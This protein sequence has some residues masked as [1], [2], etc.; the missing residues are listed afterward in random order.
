MMQDN[1]FGLEMMFEIEKPQL[2]PQ[3][4]YFKIIY[5]VGYLAISTK[6]N[7]IFIS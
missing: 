3:L 6:E 5:L 1:P 7:V 4:L 2:M